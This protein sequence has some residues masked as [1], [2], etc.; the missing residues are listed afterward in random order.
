MKRTSA[1]TVLSIIAGAG[2][3]S[4]LGLTLWR[5]AGHSLP[6]VPWMV[7]VVMVVMAVALLIAGWP[8]GQV[9]REAREAA[10]RRLEGKEE[11]K[12]RTHFVDPLR[13]ARIFVL[14]KAA[15]LTGALLTG[16][17]G[18]TLLILLTGPLVEARLAQVWPAATATGAA[19]ILL[20]SGVIVEWFC[21]LPPSDDAEGELA[22]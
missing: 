8:V 12:K 9:T 11:G 5:R 16:W 1:P 13:A 21:E 10:E 6:P 22:N 17:Y 19:V 7:A 3:V 18:T 2:G 4:W 15:T 14:A 20:I